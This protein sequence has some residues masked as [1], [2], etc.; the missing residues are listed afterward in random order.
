VKHKHLDDNF[1][2]TTQI[3]A[4]DVAALAAQG[5]RSILCN[6][7]D[8]EAQGQP[9]FEQVASAAAAVGMTAHYLPAE[10]GKVTDA[11]ARALSGILKTLP[12]PVLA[13]CKTGRRSATLWALAQ[14][15]DL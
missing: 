1:A 4:D 10:S 6:R 9:S 3:T 2:I 15:D 5:F 12:T 7:P 14:A 8:G 11:H 13:Y